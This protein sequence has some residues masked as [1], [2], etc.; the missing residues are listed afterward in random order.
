VSGTA[1][2]TE[3]LAGAPHLAEGC[4]TFTAPAGAAASGSATVRVCLCQGEAERD[5]RRAAVTPAAG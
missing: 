5:C 2:R 3:G 4:G 1:L